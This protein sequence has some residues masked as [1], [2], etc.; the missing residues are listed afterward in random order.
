VT[1]ICL[2]LGAL[3]AILALGFYPARPETP[4][5]AVARLLSG[6]VDSF[7]RMVAGPFTEAVQ[8]D[9]GQARLQALFLETRLAYKRWEWAAEYWNPL[10]AR[11][12][13]GEPVPEADPVVQADPTPEGGIQGR[14]MI[15][16]PEGLQVIE[17]LLFPRYDTSGRQELLGR[18]RRLREVAVQ[19]KNYFDNNG[20]L[21]GQI[22]D[23]ARLEVFRVLTLGIAGFDAQLTLNSM[24]ESV[25]ALKG[26]TAAMS[27]YH[28]SDSLLVVLGTACAYLHRHADFNTFDRAVFITR[29]GNPVCRGIAG[30]EERLKIPVIRYNRLLRQEAVTLFDTGAFN[31]DAYVPDSGSPTTPPLVSLGKMLFSDPVLS[32]PGNRSCASCHRPEL[33]FTDGL[34]RNTVLNGHVLLPRNTPTLL[35]A[36]LQP[37]Q[38]Y[39]LRAATLEEQVR[40]VLNNPDE[41][42][43]SL[44]R[45]LARMLGD[46]AYASLIAAAF[47]KGG[48]DTAHIVNALAAYVRSLVRLDSR[49]DR[50]MRGDSAVLSGDEIEGFNLFMGKARCGTCHYMPLFNGNFPPMYNRTEAEVIGVPAAAGSGA[51]DADEG[52][53]AILPAPFLQHAFKTPTLRNAGLTAPY[54]HNGIYGTL[55]KVVD[56]YDDGGGSGEGEHLVNQ[57]LPR[58]SLHLSTEE[59]KALVAFVHSLNS[60]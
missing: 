23:A 56:F 48:S 50:F 11:R 3:G 29:Y 4:E 47:P 5:Q 15:V 53:F 1:R 13:N 22:F 59:K 35:N 19:Y 28:G 26:V 20:I 57:T 31:A 43:G 51:V 40:D 52:Q 55:E 32:G 8:N 41:M 45:V 24:E 46:S 49:F 34:I 38:F 60:R 6:Q 44:A 10:Q 7:E 2:I 58:D 54:M 25:E 12:I 30:L 16:Q 9:A 17:G 39:D 36:A 42:Q 33:A 27:F 21:P 18:L 37:A 14:F